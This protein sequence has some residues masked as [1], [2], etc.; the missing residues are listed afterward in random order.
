MTKTAERVR[1]WRKRTK[2]K[3]VEAMGG[4][5]VCCG[6]NKCS[7]ALVLHHLDP[8]QKEMGLGALRA[9]CSSWGK[10]VKEL[11]KCILVCANCHAEIHAGL[12]KIPKICSTF[13]EDYVSYDFYF[14][15]ETEVR[16]CE[17][18]N[19]TYETKIN[20]KRRF[21]SNKCADK[22]NRKIKCS[23]EEL[24][25]LKLDNNYTIVQLAEMFKVSET[26]IRKRLRA[27]A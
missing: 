16:M 5:C 26:A 2:Q 23:N 22:S 18:C 19:T 3:I 8:S 7:G 6:Y 14:R 24:L 4:K 27:V 10:I 15:I 12:T 20:S 11:R 1:R 25:K 17:V 9:S 21:C 13:N